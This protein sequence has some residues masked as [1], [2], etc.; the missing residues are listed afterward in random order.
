MALDRN[1]HGLSR[2]IPVDIRKKVRRRCGFGCVICGCAVITYEHFKPRYKDAK[3]HLAEGIT[4]LCGHHQLESTKGILSLETIMKADAEPF[5]KRVGYSNQLL[6]IGNSKPKIYLGNSNLTACGP[7]IAFNGDILLKIQQPER[8]SSKWRLSATFHE[9]SGAVAC[10]IV[11]NE[12]VVNEALFDFE[13]VGT[14]FIAK[15]A[16]GVVL[17]M[18]LIPP[19]ILRINQYKLFINGGV[20]F[21]GK[22]KIKNILSEELEEKSVLEFKRNNKVVFTSVGDTFRSTNGINFTL[23]NN[24]VRLSSISI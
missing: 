24:G 21:I 13:Q 12:L 10:E 4:L 9:Q 2:Y 3:K 19:N 14:K 23:S 11:E 16:K 8:K 17:E 18:E 22:R 20:L 1:K 15:D 7:V 6:D 5:C